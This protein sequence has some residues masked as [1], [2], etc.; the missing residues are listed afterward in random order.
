[1]FFTSMVKVLNNTFNSFNDNGFDRVDPNV[2]QYFRTEFGKDWK[3]A[4][5]HHL[6]KKSLKNDKKA[7]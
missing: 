6:Y 2:V 7:A 3:I 4:L 1:M 5:Q